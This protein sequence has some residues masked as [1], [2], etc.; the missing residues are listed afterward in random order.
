[1]KY[2]ALVMI[3]A[4][5]VFAGISY[6]AGIKKRITVCLLSADFLR[7]AAR[8]SEETGAEL[9]T[10]L[11]FL[12]KRKKYEAF[13]FP[14][15]AARRLEEGDELSR[16][17]Q[18]AISA[19]GTLSA[20]SGCEREMIFSVHECFDSA[21][22]RELCQRLGSV[23]DRLTESASEEKKSAERNGNAAI[24][25]SVLGAAALFIILL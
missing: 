19:D 18:K 24:G 5:I 23:A 8:Y 1:M 9:T 6:T 17:W 7:D 14:L 20:L 11:F 22:V 3:C 13:T 21:S 12:S 25:L 2:A 15:E 10:T 16:A 4:P